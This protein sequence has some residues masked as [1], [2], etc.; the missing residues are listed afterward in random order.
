MRYHSTRN[1][2][3]TV[4]ARQALMQGLCEDG[5]LYVSDELG[6][7]PIDLK[8][9]LHQDYLTLAT[10]VL[11]ALLDDFT[12]SELQEAVRKAYLGKFT[13]EAITPVSALGNDWLLELYHGPTSAFKD[14]ALC[15]LPQL[16][17]AVLRE[18]GERVMIATATSGDTGKAALSGFADVPHIGIA[19]FYP[20][21]KVSALQ[22]LQMVTQT[23]S[24]VAVAAVQGNFDDVQSAVKRLF[25]SAHQDGFIPGVRLSSANSINIGRL[26][27]QVVYYFD[28]YRQLVNRGVI[29]LGEPVDFSVPTGNFGD[30]LA[31]YFAKRMGLPVRHFIVASNTNHVLTDFITTG[32]YDRRRAFEKTISPSMDILISSN[33]ERLLYYVSEGNDTL[34]KTL[35]QQLETEGRYEVPAELL[36]RIQ[37]VFLSG[38]A[39]DDETR[40]TIRS[41]WKNEHRLIDP[42][43]A[44]A[45]HVA[46]KV[47]SAE[48]TT[49][50]IVV[51]T[52]SPYKFCQDVYRALAGE[53]DGC[54]VNEFAYM[55]ALARLT[56]TTPPAALAELERAEVLHTRTLN[57]DG[58]PSFVRASAERAFSKPSE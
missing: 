31:G 44:V 34:V 30:V 15:L 37:S 43:T 10:T 56:Q 49:P 57:V 19:V 50:L 5:G 23:G 32:V 8:G 14:V 52:A 7:T 40:E 25:K 26:V 13:H 38:W 36:A 51:S 6:A 18:T 33:L 29:A 11:H 46:R 12:E 1:C 28:A 16:M 53:L 24:N 22:R 27:P 17:S 45:F 42:H 48:D 47:R 58:L 55:K 4:N 9:L 3:V 20:E 39:N 35:M 41:V 21:G 2:S 54:G